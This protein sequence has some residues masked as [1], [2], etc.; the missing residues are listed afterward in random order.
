MEEF[1]I[2]I[3]SNLDDKGYLIVKREEYNKLKSAQLRPEVAAF[4]QRI[5]S[6]I[7]FLESLKLRKVLSDVAFMFFI[8]DDISKF[9]TDLNEKKS[10]CD[11]MPDLNL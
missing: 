9:L 6:K 3:I 2:S 5:N 4:A 7:D 8:Q 11:S 1:A 10:K